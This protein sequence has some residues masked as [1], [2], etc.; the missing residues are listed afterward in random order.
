MSQHDE[1]YRQEALDAYAAAHIE[2][3]VLPPV[4]R[5]TQVLFWLSILLVAA[6]VLLA[7]TVQ[8]PV[9]GTGM[10][11]PVAVRL[12]PDLAGLLGEGGQ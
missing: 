2:E 1:I 7:F 12:W 4:A 9:P 8:V 11:Q 5:W 10:R 6:A 3:T